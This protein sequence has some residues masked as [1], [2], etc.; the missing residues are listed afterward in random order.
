MSFL[1]LLWYMLSGHAVADYA[2]QSDAMAKGKNWNNAT[3][4]PPGQKPQVCWYYWMAAHA[5]VHG[6]AVTLV[7]QSVAL[8]VAE[9]VV[10]FVID[11]LKCA[12]IT[13]INEDQLAHVLCKILWAS[14]ALLMR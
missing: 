12:G 13:T 7:T 2:L 5:L 8:G 14:I 9:T 4:V 11:C 3:P 6:G 10:H 1:T